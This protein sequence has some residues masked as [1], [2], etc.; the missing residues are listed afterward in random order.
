MGARPRCDQVVEIGALRMSAGEPI[1]YLVFGIETRER[2]DAID[3]LPSVSQLGLERQLLT[4]RNE[5]HYLVRCV[6]L[7]VS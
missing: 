2:N 3:M 6:L 5:A 1:A 4:H 7:D